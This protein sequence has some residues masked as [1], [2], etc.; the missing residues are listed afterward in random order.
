MKTN[1]FFLDHLSFDGMKYTN[2]FKVRVLNQKLL[3][4]TFFGDQHY[5]AGPK[6]VYSSCL[7]VET[8]ILQERVLEAAASP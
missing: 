2:L 6:A 5:F 7:L 8:P 3:L 4:K 1:V